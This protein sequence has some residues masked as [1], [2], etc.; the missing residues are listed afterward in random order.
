[1]IMNQNRL[2]PLGIHTTFGK[3]KAEDGAGRV[4]KVAKEHLVSNLLEPCSDLP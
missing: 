2:L 4:E 1:M 3:A